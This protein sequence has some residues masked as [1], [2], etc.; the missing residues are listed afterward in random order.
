ML[1]IKELLEEIKASPY[2]EVEI[3]VPHT[4][5]VEFSDLKVGDKVTGPTGEWK[6]KPGT[7]LAKLTRERN[8]KSIPA[9]EKGEIVS[10]RHDL[11]GKFVEAGEVLLR[12]RHFLSKEEV[13]QLIL[14]KALFLFNAPE[15]AKYYFTPEIDTKIKGSGERSVKVRDG[16][17]LFIVSRMKRETPLNYTGPEGVIYAVYFHNGDNIDGGQPLIGVCPE[18]QLKHIQDV[19][20]RVQS[21]WEERD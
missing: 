6:E 7:V 5:I 17:E 13:I 9:P 11:E 21:E 10:I 20:T 8:T 14:K 1:N 16:L 19:V 18:D 15:K 3:S 12:I 4:G 2:E